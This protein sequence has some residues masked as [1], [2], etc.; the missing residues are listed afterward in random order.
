MNEVLNQLQAYVHAS[1][2]KQ[3]ITLISVLDEQSH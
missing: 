2:G 3:H 1:A